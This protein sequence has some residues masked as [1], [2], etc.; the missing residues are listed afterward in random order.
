MYGLPTMRW[1][2]GTGLTLRSRCEPEAPRCAR[3]ILA[4]R[5]TSVPFTAVTSGP[6]RTLT[7]N[8]T[9]GRDLCRSVPPQVTI[10]LELAL[11][12]RGRR[13]PARRTLSQLVG[14]K[15]SLGLSNTYL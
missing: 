6:Q 8:T 2:L 12:A 10:V 11:G 1:W 5:A 4:G 7:D 14:P 3:V 13:L 15:P 9:A